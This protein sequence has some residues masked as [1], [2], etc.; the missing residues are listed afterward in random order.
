MLQRPLVVL[1]VLLSVA[2]AS[3]TMTPRANTR[4]AIESYVESAAKLVAS[5]GAAACD[6]FKQPAWYAGEW[7]IFVSEV[8]GALVCHPARPD[9]VGMPQGD[10]VD[11]NGKR[12]GEEF[13]LAAS[14]PAESGWV[15]YVWARPGE[16]TPVAKSSYVRRVVGSDGKVYIVGSGGYEVQ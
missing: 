5:N 8:N 6:T 1:S 2:C 3:T 9:M 15:D 16:T 14:S 11:P 12:I 13:M 4:A 10:I 7:Y